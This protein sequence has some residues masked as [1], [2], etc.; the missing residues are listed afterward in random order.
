MYIMSIGFFDAMQ[1]PE[2]LCDIPRSFPLGQD[3]LDEFAPPKNVP[4]WDEDYARTTY[5]RRVGDMKMELLG[6][7][8]WLWNVSEWALDK[9]IALT[10]VTWIVLHLNLVSNQ[11]GFKPLRFHTT[12]ACDRGMMDIP[13]AAHIQPAP[14]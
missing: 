3:I 11:F 6:K 14:R 12:I 10:Q 4:V 5:A 1:W 9:F 13:V 8:Y 7:R 2:F